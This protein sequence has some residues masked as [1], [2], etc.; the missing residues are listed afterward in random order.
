MARSGRW[1]M[2][3]IIAHL[4]VVLLF[5][6]T[7]RTAEGKVVPGGFNRDRHASPE[8]QRNDDIVIPRVEIARVMSDIAGDKLVLYTEDIVG[9]TFIVDR[10]RMECHE[11]VHV[12]ES[13][14]PLEP[15]AK[16][17]EE[18]LR[19]AKILC[20]SA[21]GSPMEVAMQ[22]GAGVLENHA[23]QLMHSRA[24]VRNRRNID[25]ESEGSKINTFNSV[26]TATNNEE[27]LR[28]EGF[29]I[30]QAEITPEMEENG[31]SSVR[32]NS[33]VTLRLFGT[34]IRRNTVII[35]THE[36][37]RYLGSCQVPVTEKFHVKEAEASGRSG[38]V[39]I[40]LPEV[41]KQKKY[42]YICAKYE[43]TDPLEGSEETEKEAV[44]DTPFLH[45]GV[46]SWMRLTSHTSMLPLWLSISVI[47]VCLMFS[48]LFSGLNLGLM[49]LDRTDLKIL[50]NTGSDT[51]KKYANAIKPIRDHGNFLLCSILL[52]N[53]LVNSTFTILLD[54]L[55]S[56]L[57][58]VIGSTVAIVIFGEIIP[59]AICSRHGLAVGART[60]AI[61]KAVMVI[62]APLSFP[63]SKILDFVLGEEI[64]NFYD[65]E[66]LKELVKVTN[67]VNDLDKDEVKVIAGVLELRKK[68]VKD[69]MTRLED[70]Y[71][72][73]IDAVLD[74][75]TIADI[76]KSGFSRI[77]VHDGDERAD[78]I[79]I[80]HIKDLAF[81]DPDDNVPVRRMCEFYRNSIHFVFYDQT[82]DVMF[83]EFKSGTFGHMA[84][85]QR[86]NSDGDGDPFYETLGLITLEDVI[87]E[88]I[89]AEIVD[90]TDVFTDN[91]SKIRRERIKRTDIPTFVD[92]AI[93]AD[94]QGLRI[95]PQLMFATYQYISTAVSAFKRD[96]ISEPILRRLLN[97]D[98]FHQIRI[99]SKD[100]N[101]RITII[102]CGTPMDYF[103]LILEGRVEVIVGKENL[104]FE[105]GPFTHFGLQA[106]AQNASGDTS[107]NT[108]QEIM[109]SLESIAQ[110]A[111]S[112]NQFIPDY[113]VKAITDVVYLQISRIRYLAAKRATLLERS[114]K[115][116][117][118]SMDPIDPEVEQLMHSLD[119]GDQ[120]SITPDA[121]NLT[122]NSGAKASKSSSNV[123]SPTALNDLTNNTNSSVTRN[124]TVLV[125]DNSS[126][127]AAANEFNIG[128]SSSYAKD[129]AVAGDPGAD[130]S[131][132]PLLPKP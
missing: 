91:R 66:R 72:L 46:D 86:V 111:A 10:R 29:R 20:W 108:P 60:I 83:K 57:F 16:E 78:I 132:I 48:A 11:Q 12:Y 5:C 39:E 30:E 93:D 99:K 79:S 114:Q 22:E 56:G 81:I 37:S 75:V 18:Y 15:V 44:K 103:V 117:D 115:L 107:A 104:L 124:H 7:W 95:G 85:V 102:N 63:I 73:P 17:D 120:N 26:Q 70:A 14:L 40:E 38:L 51:E 28:I 94:T 125:H 24:A 127:A 129:M 3:K 64:G 105:S 74:F 67:D 61:T 92:R 21:Q 89:Q 71:M 8:M 52:G 54:G 106:I 98:I 126:S 34:G 13:F 130:P 109:G 76:M 19:Q 49:S 118:Q 97:Q 35:F 84:F 27:V 68:T 80:L 112:R 33:P 50:C 36:P 128:A 23:N 25:R 69:V 4:T 100:R 2:L 1:E 116:G 45:Q 47:C 6:D 110:D 96:C 101:E 119:K 59:Q 65:R 9:R 41:I 77:P 88:L 55:T 82:L 90:E 32:V 43:K 58:A 31:V 53:V 87:E 131:S 122:V 123:A 121:T 42:F 62:T 113:T